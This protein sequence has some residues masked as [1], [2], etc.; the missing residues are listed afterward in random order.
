MGIFHDD[1]GNA[2][3]FEG[4]VNETVGGWKNNYER[5]KIHRSWVDQ[6]SA[7]V[8]S[9]VDTFRRLWEDDHPYVKV[10]DLPEAIIQDLIDW[11]DPD[12]QT[13][14]EEAIQIARGEAPPTERDK[15]NIIA[16]GHLSPGGLA[17]A[18]EASTITPW[19]HQRVVSDTLV[20][21]YPNSF[22]LCDEVG[23][24]KTIEAGLTL[25]RLGLT[26]ELE[27]GLL[28][29][30]ASLA[31]QWQEEMWEKFNLNTYRYERGSEYEYAFIDAFGREQYPPAAS[32]LDGQIGFQRHLQQIIDTQ[33]HLNH[34]HRR[35]FD[36]FARSY[37][38]R[39]YI[40]S[41]FT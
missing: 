31:V 14:L 11:K 20:N 9:D 33:R 37:T 2:I 18:E 22:L 40:C 35:E 8:D 38:V 30:P 1:A 24:G 25:S 26:N 21:T 13:Q 7:Y 3:S 19:P 16:D 41:Q 6:Q 4:S 28:L 10:H 17:L 15:A 32:E 36:E 39:R 12:S 27:T 5:F 23:L 34:V 29:V